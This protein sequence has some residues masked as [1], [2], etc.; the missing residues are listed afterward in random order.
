MA[1]KIGKAKA[2]G[3]VASRAMKRTN[4]PVP[5][6]R[7]M[8][9]LRA[10]SNRTLTQDSRALLVSELNRGID[11]NYECRWPTSIDASMYKSLF[12]RN[13]VANRVVTFWPSECWIQPPEIY[14]NEKAQGE[15]EFERA[16]KELESRL[17]LIAKLYV[18]DI[19]SR[20][21]RYGVILLG[22]SDLGPNDALN[23]PVDGL[24][25]A[26]AAK[27]EGKTGKP[28]ELRLLYVKTFQEYDAAIVR[29]DTDVS[30]PRYGMPL[31]YQINVE[32]AGGDGMTTS[33]RVHWTRVLHIADNRLS[34]DVY[35][36]PAMKPVWDDLVD[37]R[38]V[39]G[40][41]SEGYWRACLSGTMWGLDPQLMDP[42]T[43]ISDDQKE[44]LAEEF[45]KYHN[46]LQHDIICAG[47]IP[48]DV[49]PKL[50]DPTPFVESLIKLICIQ[51]GAP[52]RVFMGAEEGK[53][54][55]GQ[56]RSAWLERV[57]G[58]QTNY[59]TPMVVGPFIERLQL[60]GALPQTE[61]EIKIDWPER[62]KPTEAG[63][64]DTA[65]KVTQALSQYATGG[66]N[67]VMGEREYFGQVLKKTPEEIN[68]IAEEVE[69][70]EEDN[71]VLEGENTG[72]PEEEPGGNKEKS[73]VEGSPNGAE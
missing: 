12:E 30:S 64:A 44:T 42:N 2:S 66:V 43:T 29:R 68:A 13:G 70:W 72:K 11:M 4:V 28:L 56:D 35:G 63:I 6:G 8:M 57:K 47:L 1:K 3:S 32:S 51:I 14:E 21:G 38:K 40:G 41:A 9:T 17:H 26:I 22:L 36:E 24:E 34:S 53:L 25:D 46:T 18:A 37:A 65:V 71:T 58:R 15:S 48:H 55:G 39:K 33:I 31:E 7:W 16:W 59:L 62:D 27:A 73:P 5:F 45:E 67:Q 50:V 19:L 54:A 61:N 60:C 20:I 52:Y 23:M 49:A 69:D 10:L